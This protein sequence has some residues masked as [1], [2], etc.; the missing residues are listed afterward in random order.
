MLFPM[1]LPCFLPMFFCDSTPGAAS[2]LSASNG[3]GKLPGALGGWG[4]WWVVDEILVESSP[5]I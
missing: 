2:E 3:P 1:V 4:G 5:W